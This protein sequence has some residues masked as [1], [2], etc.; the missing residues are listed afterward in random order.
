MFA[1]EFRQNA[2]GTLGSDM[3]PTPIETKIG[4]CKFWL[5]IYI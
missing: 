2:R 3:T 5:P 1:G 4:G